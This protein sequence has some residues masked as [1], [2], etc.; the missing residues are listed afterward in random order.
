MANKNIIKVV[1]EEISKFGFDFLHNEEYLKEEENYDLLKN[2][3]FQKQFICDSLINPKKVIKHVSEARVG[4]NWQNG[5]DADKLTIEYFLNVEYKY[6]ETKEPA[7]FNIDFFSEDI[8]IG[9]ATQSEPG[10]YGNFVEPTFEAGYTNLNW[11]DINVTMHTLK[12]DEIDFVAFEKA[13]PKIQEL[14]IREFVESFIATETADTD[15]LKKDN[16]KSVPYC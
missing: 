8:G 5:D 6:D 10:S 1:N 3:D 13:P 12:G 15:Y 4:G 16:I 11:N 7:K 14:F 2:E 9:I